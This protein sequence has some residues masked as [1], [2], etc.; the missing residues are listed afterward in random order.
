MSLKIYPSNSSRKC[1]LV[2]KEKQSKSTNTLNTMQFPFAMLFILLSQGSG[3]T[4]QEC[5][6]LFS[7]T[8]N[9]SESTSIK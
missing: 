3:H 8:F 6:V 1:Y 5:N 9:S 2:L 4:F 7:F